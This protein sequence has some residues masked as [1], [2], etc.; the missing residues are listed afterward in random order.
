MLRPR[1]TSR[2]PLSRPLPTKASSRSLP[3][4]WRTLP[5]PNQSPRYVDTDN[6]PVLS[7][8]AP[9][10]TPLLL[11][12]ASP[13]PFSKAE[14]NAPAAAVEQALEASAEA[15][16]A[17]TNHADSVAAAD[18][19]PAPSAPPATEAPAAEEV[20]AQDSTVAESAAVDIEPGLPEEV[21]EG[22]PRQDF[23]HVS[24]CCRT[25]RGDGRPWAAFSPQ[26]FPLWRPCRTHQRQTP[27]RSP[28]RMAQRKWAVMLPRLLRRTSRQMTLPWPRR[29]RSSHRRAWPTTLHS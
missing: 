24:F 9:F 14:E 2:P 27:P 17:F 29:K 6:D 22:E 10:L 1:P 7:P 25:G 13:N 23:V 16:A 28:P 21:S 3:L 18:D 8:P 26:P 11:P 15:A 12:S 4:R 5:P 20:P 19:E